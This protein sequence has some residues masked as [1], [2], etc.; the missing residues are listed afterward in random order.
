MLTIYLLKDFRGSTGEKVIA[1]TITSIV[2][3]CIIVPTVLGIM[4]IL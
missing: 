3:L 2:D 4:G 1:T